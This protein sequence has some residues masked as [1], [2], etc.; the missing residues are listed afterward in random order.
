MKFQDALPPIEIVDIDND[1]LLIR[2]FGESVPVVEIDG[3]VRFRGAVNPVLFQRLIDAA[4][5][6]SS[7][8]E[9][10]P[11]DNKPVIGFT[12]KTG[13]NVSFSERI[14]N[15]RAD[16]GLQFHQ[17]LYTSST[18]RTVDGAGQRGPRFF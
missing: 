8:Q 5:L 3:Q 17:I 15:G 2:Q 18:H 10:D 9:I 13:P 6:R 16:I 1:P 14:E 4:E 7:M 11:P 12:A